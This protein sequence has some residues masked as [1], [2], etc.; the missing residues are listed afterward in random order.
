MRDSDL[1]SKSISKMLR[2]SS[3]LYPARDNVVFKDKDFIG[4]GILDSIETW[5]EVVRTK[6]HG[7]YGRRAEMRMLAQLQ[8]HR[9]L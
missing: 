5:H 4:G 6:D 3:D 9:K 7:S 2:Y 8:V 1:L